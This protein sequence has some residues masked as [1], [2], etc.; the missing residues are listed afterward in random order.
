MIENELSLKRALLRFSAQDNALLNITFHSFHLPLSKY[1]IIV[2][3][4]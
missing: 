1:V 2:V 3:P 4:G